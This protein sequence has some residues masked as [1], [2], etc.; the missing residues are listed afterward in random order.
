MNS[1]QY[2]NIIKETYTKL[3]GLN[4]EDDFF[5]NLDELRKS[6]SKFQKEATDISLYPNHSEGGRDG[7]KK[8]RALAHDVVEDCEKLKIQFKFMD[9][10]INNS[11]NFVY[12][13]Y[14]NKNITNLINI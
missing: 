7:L 1:K 8:L 14:Q 4:L 9:I 12:Y 11:D 13:K 10:K 6:N 5:E 3:S 2:K